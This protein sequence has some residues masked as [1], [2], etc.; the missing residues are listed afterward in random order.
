MDQ[1]A[2]KYLRYLC[3]ALGLLYQVV[4]CG[5]GVEDERDAV[6]GEQSNHWTRYP[7]V[8]GIL[9]GK[10]QRRKVRRIVRKFEQYL[11]RLCT[12]RHGR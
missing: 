1:K 3:I 4:V 5:S 8:A 10:L 11:E 12:G 2:N 6:L 7:N 9:P